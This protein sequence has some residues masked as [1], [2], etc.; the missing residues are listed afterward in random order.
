MYEDITSIHKDWL[1]DRRDLE[2]FSF[3]FDITKFGLLY[4]SRQG[5]F[6]SWENS[7]A[8]LQVGDKEDGDP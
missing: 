8:W 6:Y 5:E 3:L 2:G 4:S 1:S 7:H